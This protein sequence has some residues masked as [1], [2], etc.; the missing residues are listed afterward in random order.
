MPLLI[1]DKKGDRVIT[2]KKFLEFPRAVVHV[3]FLETLNH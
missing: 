1:Q 2:L 3:T